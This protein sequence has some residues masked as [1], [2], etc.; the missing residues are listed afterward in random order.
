MRRKCASQNGWWFLRIIKLMC[1]QTYTLKINKLLGNLKV[2]N[3][4]GKV[5]CYITKKADKKK[6]RKMRNKKKVFYF[7]IKSVT[8]EAI[9]ILKL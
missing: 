4:I 1:K 7:L 5:K 2:C 3:E 8:C 6:N 9:K